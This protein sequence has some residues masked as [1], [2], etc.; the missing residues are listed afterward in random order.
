MKTELPD[1]FDLIPHKNKFVI[2]DKEF[3]DYINNLKQEKEYYKQKCKYIEEYIKSL[4]LYGLRSGKT[5]IQSICNDLLE[6]IE[7]R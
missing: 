5:F 3:Y 4:N 2:T 7:K 1:I 6:I